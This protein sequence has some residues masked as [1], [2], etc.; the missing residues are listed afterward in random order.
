M[1][2]RND[3]A[4]KRDHWIALVSSLMD[5]IVRWCEQHG[6]SVIRSTKRVSEEHIGEYEV[7]ALTI[8]TPAIQLHI[9][10]VGLNIIGAQGRVDIL[11]Y[12]SLNRL[13]LVRKDDQWMLFTESRVA[14]PQDWGSE[15]FAKITRSL[16]A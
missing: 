8:H 13:L 6:W 11:A 12:P 16:A 14:W 3:W 15:T 10:P 9:D 7:P 1:P 4:Q 2:D 5:D